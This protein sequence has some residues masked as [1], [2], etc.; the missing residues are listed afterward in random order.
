M[1]GVR[2]EG[3][4]AIDVMAKEI[5]EV[6]SYFWILPVQYRVDALK[7][8]YKVSSTVRSVIKK[9]GGCNCGK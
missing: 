5:P 6:Q 1:D 3:Q 9:T 7:L 2:Y 8:T 4:N